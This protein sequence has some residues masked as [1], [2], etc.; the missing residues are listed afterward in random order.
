MLSPFLPFIRRLVP[1]MCWSWRV[2]KHQSLLTKCRMLSAK[3]NFGKA[4][5]VAPALLVLHTGAGGCRKLPAGCPHLQPGQRSR[6]EEADLRITRSW[7]LSV[8]S[9]RVFY[10]PNCQTPFPALRHF[11]D[12]CLCVFL[13]WFGFFFFLIGLH[14][15]NFGGLFLRDLEQLLLRAQSCVSSRKGQIS[16]SIGDC[17][18]PGQL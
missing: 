8:S 13:S 17:K 6:A 4:D 12:V 18:S 10:P 3:F 16:L 7:S 1:S 2:N 15:L 5:P 11:R 9:G 14:V